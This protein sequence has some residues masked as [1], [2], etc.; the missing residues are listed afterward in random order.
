MVHFTDLNLKKNPVTKSFGYSC[1]L[2]GKKN[3]IE[4]FKIGIVHDSCYLIN[5]SAHF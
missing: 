4:Y 2:K 5:E 3:L 1:R